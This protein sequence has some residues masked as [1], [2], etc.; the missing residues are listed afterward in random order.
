MWS[1]V[2]DAEGA[3]VPEPLEAME[4]PSE[5]KGTE[6]VRRGGVAALAERV[7]LSRMGTLLERR[8][9]RQG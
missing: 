7:L 8:A 4:L 2:P 3:P 5:R 1:T 6:R 9:Q